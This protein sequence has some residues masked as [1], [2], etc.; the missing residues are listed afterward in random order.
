MSDE[1]FREVDEEYRRDKVSEIWKKYNTLIIGVVA[2]V[3]IGVG[4]YRYWEGVQLQK[5]QEASTAYMQA[6]NLAATGKEA[7]AEKALVALGKEGS[8]GYGLL[9]KFLLAS[10]TGHSN[11]DAAIQQYSA[12]ALDNTI[13]AEWRDLA[14]L[15]GAMLKMDVGDGST[16]QADLEQLA[17]ANS[18]WRHTAREMLGLSAL[19][20]NDYAAA[21]RWFDLIAQ[22]NETPQ[23]L[24]GR[25][26][27]YAAVVEGGPVQVAR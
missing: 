2:I 7:D 23:S 25:L 1:F 8:S 13:P 19:K 22:D 15:R 14:K 26:A 20:R 10:E 17:T 27:L 5:A 24:R 6:A 16:A 9:S 12:L 18:A 11:K 21:R 3:V 4:G